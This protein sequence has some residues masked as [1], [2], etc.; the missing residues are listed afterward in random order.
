[1][2]RSMI[3]SDAT[4]RNIKRGDPRKR[5]SDGEG[6]YLLLFV[7]TYGARMPVVK[8]GRMA[9]DLITRSTANEKP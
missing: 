2:A 3:P 1:M 7:L 9:G 5:L 6:L 4:I 8:V